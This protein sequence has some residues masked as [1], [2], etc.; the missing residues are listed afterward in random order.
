MTQNIKGPIFFKAC[1]SANSLL[2][3]K[4]YI[5]LLSRFPEDMKWIKY[6]RESVGTGVFVDDLISYAFV[7]VYLSEDTTFIGGE[8]LNE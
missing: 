8:Y 6:Q 7:G 2:G 5:Y 1:T 4:K 3:C